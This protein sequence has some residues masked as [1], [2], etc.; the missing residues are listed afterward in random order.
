MSSHAILLSVVFS[1]QILI[2]L[3]GNSF[4]LCFFIIT[5]FVGHKLR[6]TDII[7]AQLVWVNSLVL[8]F[9]GIPE[10]VANLGL[11]NFLDD[12]GCKIVFYV[13]KTCRGISISMTCLLSVFQAITINPRSYRWAKFKAKATK[14]I[15]PC[16]LL[17]WFLQLLLNVIVLE[18]IQGPR[19]S[20]NGSEILSYGYC[21]V[22]EETSISTELFVIVVALP[23]VVCL[24]LMVSASG[25][26]VW[27]L[28]RHHKQVKQIHMTSLSSRVPPEIK[29]TQSILLLVTTFVCFYALNFIFFHIYAFQKAKTLVGAV[30]CL[31]GFL[32]PNF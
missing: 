2:G 4:L 27:L 19:A 7:L 9:K 13:S 32:F 16:S 18:K 25:Y 15:I 24:W 20:S 14:S 23:E 12:N 31:S 11:K 8:L 29:A 30:L 17:C 26:M 1:L 5:F 22:L 28:D 3:L 21:I 10:T 6:P